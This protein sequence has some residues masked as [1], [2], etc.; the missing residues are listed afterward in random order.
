MVDI[1]SMIS[2]YNAFKTGARLARPSERSEWQFLNLLVAFLF[3]R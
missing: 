3:L 2:L 1:R